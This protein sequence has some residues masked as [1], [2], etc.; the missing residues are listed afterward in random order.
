MLAGVVVGERMAD[1]QVE[2]RSAG[3]R[4][5]PSLVALTVA[6]YEEDGFTATP[7]ALRARFDE[8]LRQADANVTVAEVVNSGEIVGFALTTLRLILES[9]SVAELQDLYVLPDFRG[10]GIGSALVTGAGEWARTS[11]AGLM[12][13]VIA[14]N[15]RDVSHLH[16]YYATLGFVDEGRRILHRSV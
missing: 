5:L 4:D 2:L 12:E 7:E 3:T 8:F 11:S 1:G 13:V 6:F 15:G 16:R 10:G 14:P 9:G